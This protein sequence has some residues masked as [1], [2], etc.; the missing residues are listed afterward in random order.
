MMQAIYLIYL[1]V[2]YDLSQCMKLLKK[3]LIMKNFAIDRE[4]HFL[5]KFRNYNF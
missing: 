3:C 2:S 1:S 5:Q 4:L